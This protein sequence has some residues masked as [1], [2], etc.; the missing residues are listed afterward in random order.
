MVQSIDKIYFFNFLLNQGYI[1]IV[2]LLTY[3]SHRLELRQT[4]RDKLF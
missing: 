2:F 3:Q 4:S 1:F